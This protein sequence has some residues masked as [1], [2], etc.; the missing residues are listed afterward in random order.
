MG[1]KMKITVKKHEGFENGYVVG[2]S[3][4]VLLV[5]S[6]N[7][8]INY[9]LLNGEKRTH[10]VLIAS[11]SLPESIMDLEL[12]LMGHKFTYCGTLYENTKWNKKIHQFLL[13]VEIDNAVE[14]LETKKEYFI[15][16][17]IEQ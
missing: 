5:P 15:F 12:M 8:I 17:I 10:F 11:D 9:F 16:K 3:D 13:N 1:E 6:K 4:V 14:K 2:D 7:N